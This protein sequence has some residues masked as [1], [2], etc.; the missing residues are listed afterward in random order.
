LDAKSKAFP[1]T[2]AKLTIGDQALVATTTPQEPAVT[3]K[4]KLQPGKFKLQSWFQNAA[5]EDQCGAYFAEVRFA[6]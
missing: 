1:I 4:L 2:S 6:K 3:F 5:G